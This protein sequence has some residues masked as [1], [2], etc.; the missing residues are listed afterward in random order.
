MEYIDIFDVNYNHIGKEEKD[1]AHLDGLWHQTFHCWIIRPDNKILFQLRS[2]IKSTF[3]NLLHVSAAGHLSAG[4][5]IEDGIREM[6]EELGIDVDFS[7]LSLVGVHKQVVDIPTSKGTFFNREFTHTYFL[8]DDTPL[9]KYLQQPEEVDGVYE[10]DIND[11]FRLFNDEADEVSVY[12]F[13]RELN[14][15]ETIKVNKARFVNLGVSYFNKLFIMA[16]R[17]IQGEKYL[18][19]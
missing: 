8:N 3:P 16:E 15:F 17:F 10:L 19:F 1:K 14:D 6:K 12:G 9:D 4:E 5:S 2:K 7:K 18:G 13:N 11:A